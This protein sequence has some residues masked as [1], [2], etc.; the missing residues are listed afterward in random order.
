MARH[1][2]KLASV[3]AAVLAACATTSGG[4]AA[5]GTSMPTPLAYPAAPREDVVDV[6]HGVPVADPYRWL[7]D[8]RSPRTQAWVASEDRLSRD[9]LTALPGRGAIAKRLEE[10]LYVEQVVGLPVKRGGRV[11]YQRRSPSQEKAVLYWREGTGPEK[12][13]LDPNG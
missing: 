4:A 1:P 7:E 3:A 10:L 5:P 13:L 6:I 11:F 2:T 12:V 8:A 9:F